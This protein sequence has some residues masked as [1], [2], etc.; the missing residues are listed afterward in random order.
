MLIADPRVLEEAKKRYV[1]IS[2]VNQKASHH[3]QTGTGFIF[4]TGLVVTC[5]HVQNLGTEFLVQGKPAKILDDGYNHSDAKDGVD[6]ML[7]ATETPEM[8]PLSFS[9]EYEI[10]S[11]VFWFSEIVSFPGALPGAIC[12]FNDERI[13]TSQPMIHGAS[14]SLLW[15][16]FKP[17]PIGVMFEL[18]E[19]VDQPV[20]FGSAIPASKVIAYL[21]SALSRI[22]KKGNL[23]LPF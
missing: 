16:A 9:E 14:G 15:H 6:L 13:I 7:L 8:Q 18:E 3:S 19:T 21:R 20:V 4:R 11:P 12:N 10:L 5:E 1:S 17:H 23:K 22:E 2:A